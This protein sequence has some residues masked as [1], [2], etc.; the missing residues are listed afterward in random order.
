M[1]TIEKRYCFVIQIAK[2]EGSREH[3]FV[4]GC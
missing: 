4:I 1:W 2:V 3:W